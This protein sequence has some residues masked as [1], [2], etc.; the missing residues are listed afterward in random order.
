MKKIFLVVIL[1]C[2]FLLANAESEDVYIVD[3]FSNMSDWNLVVDNG[4]NISTGS[5]F[6]GN[7]L[8]FNNQENYGDNL[9]KIT[10]IYNPFLDYN[11]IF[12]YFYN[13]EPYSD[14][15]L[16]IT[17]RDGVKSC[18]SSISYGFPTNKWILYNRSLRYFQDCLDK[19]FKTIGKIELIINN[20]PTKVEI[21]PIKILST[22]ATFINKTQQPGNI[23]IN[24]IEVNPS[25]APKGRGISITSTIN[26]DSFIHYVILNL[27]SQNYSKSFLMERIMG[28]DSLAVYRYVFIP[29]SENPTGNY[30]FTIKAI[31]YGGNESLTNYYKFIVN[32]SLII[33]ASY[34]HTIGPGKTLVIKGNVFDCNNMT[35]NGIITLTIDNFT[36]TKEFINNFAFFYELP[37]EAS[38]K[39]IKYF[40]LTVKDNKGNEGK[41]I[42]SF[43]V[44]PELEISSTAVPPEGSPGDEIYVNVNVS[45]KKTKEPV[46]GLNLTINNK[47]SSLKEKEPGVYEGTMILTDDDIGVLKPKILY[48]SA[49]IQELNTTILVKKK[50]FLDRREL[51]LIFTIIVF[52]F[53][54]FL[55]IKIFRENQ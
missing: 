5:N 37:S 8:L 17:D 33:D 27:Y 53:F 11:Q 32:D 16:R 48:E 21:T 40:N 39:K 45:Y 47:N 24:N 46:S 22:N 38:I 23:S 49:V 28:N 52:I 4:A 13:Y 44:S 30:N 34:N 19:N 12:F 10:E 9:Q 2:A 1:L 14:L 35:T 7:T 6:G 20:Y 3:D 25:I 42:F 50:T 18:I 29:Q 15:L 26:A 55:T 36:E 31:D 43:F 54:V 41:N 51:L